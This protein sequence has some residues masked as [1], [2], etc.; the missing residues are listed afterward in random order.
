MPAVSSLVMYFLCF[1]FFLPGY[2]FPQAVQAS[3]NKVTEGPKNFYIGKILAVTIQN[4]QKVFMLNGYS[5]DSQTEKDERGHSYSSTHYYTSPA[6]PTVRPQIPIAKPNF[7]RVAVPFVIAMWVFGTCIVKIILSG[8]PKLLTWVPESCCLILAGIAVGIVFFL[9]KTTV[10]SPLSS[11]IF[12]FC[13]LPPIIFDAGFFMPNRPFFDHL[14]TILLFAVMGTIFNTICIGMSLWACGLSG[15]YGFEI[16]LLETLI[17]SALI[18][19]VDPVAVLSVFEEIHV[20]KVLYIIVFGES[21]LNDAVTVVRFYEWKSYIYHILIMTCFLKV[22]YNMCDSYISLGPENIETIDVLSGFA[23]FL[24]VALGGTTIGIFWGFL[25]GFATKYT[26]RVLVIEPIF[27]FIMSY[28]A[29]LNAEAFQMSGIL[30]IMFCG[31]TMKNYVAENMSS[32]SLTTVKCGLKVLSNGSESIIFVFLGISTV[33]DNHEWNTA[34]IL[35]TIFFCSIYRALG[36]V[37]LTELA[38][39]FRL[40]QLNRVEKFVMSYGGLRGAIAFALVLLIDPNRIP[41]QPLFVT[42]TISVVFFTVFVQGITIKPLVEFLKVKREEK[43]E[44]TMNERLHE[45]MLDYTMAGVVDI[46]GQ[47]SSNKVRDKFKQLDY[48]Y[49]RPCLIREKNHHEPKILETYSKL[50]LQ[51]AIEFARRNPSSWTVYGTNS[52]A[53]FINSEAVANV[54]PTK[55]CESVVNIDLGELNFTPST[56]DLCDAEIHHTVLDRIWTSRRSKG[57]N[58]HSDQSKNHSKRRT[59]GCGVSRKQRSKK[60]KPAYRE[61][62]NRHRSTPTDAEDLKIRMAANRDKEGEEEGISF[63]VNLEIDGK[64]ASNETATVQEMPFPWKTDNGPPQRRD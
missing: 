15:I 35:L 2:S 9:T 32:T 57:D 24:V 49:I 36:V 14:G 62:R 18:S 33:N 37:V 23:S 6:T 10:L 40:H 19:A 22:L 43:R 59:M 5:T 58:T 11:T 63:T 30:S 28:V 13:M 27:V 12:F 60:E 29:Y 41:R 25:T 38:N 50:T 3:E 61:I 64:I 55:L 45:K 48:A 1:M 44:K 52:F 42:A 34:F 8:W 4:T 39:Y 54:P 17:F 53:N 47:L 7:P 26:H 16:S 46:L 51:D 20:D 21:L 56:K 31:I